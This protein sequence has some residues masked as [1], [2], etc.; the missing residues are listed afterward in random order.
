MVQKREPSQIRWKSKKNV[1]KL[2]CCA[3]AQ[4]TQTKDA[5][6]V[7]PPFRFR[8]CEFSHNTTRTG[9]AGVESAPPV[10][11]WVEQ[12][13][14][15]EWLRHFPQEECSWRGLRHALLSVVCSGLWRFQCMRC[16]AALQDRFY[17]FGAALFSVSPQWTATRSGKQTSTVI[18]AA[19][20]EIG[21]K[22]LTICSE[23][24][25]RIPP[26]PYNVYI[27]SPIVYPSTH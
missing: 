5:K 22:I 23:M 27:Q 1:R 17:M 6:K 25:S 15:P 11:H 14:H 2:L 9:L 7:F 16:G 19:E 24:A 12:R 18:T 21:K 8:K 10:G 20:G 4:T 13:S 26:F 3:W